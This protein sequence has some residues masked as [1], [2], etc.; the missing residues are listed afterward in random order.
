MNT[1]L[2]PGVYSRIVEIGQLPNQLG[3]IR[4]GFI[5]TAQKGPVN[6]PVLITNAQQFIDVFG[7]PFPDSYLG[8]SVL[9]YLEEGN[10]CYVMRIAVECNDGL[11]PELQEVCIDTSGSRVNGWGRLP[12][13]S[14]IDVGKIIL[15]GIGDGIGVNQSPVS[16][17]DS[18]IFNVQYTDATLSSTDG[19]TVATLSFLDDYSGDIDDSFSLVINSEPNLSE[20]SALGG[21]EFQIIRNSDGEILTTGVL[22]DTAGS[23][24]SAWVAVPDSGFSVRVEVTSGELD[25]GDTFTWNVEPDNRNFSVAVEGDL[26]PTVYQMP[27]A[28]Y[29]NIS[30]FV[31]AA[32]GLLTGEDYLFVETVDGNGNPVAAIQTV[33]EGDRIQIMSTSSWA[34]ELGSSLYAWDIPRAYLLG[35]NAGPYTFTSQNNRVILNVIGEASTQQISVSVPVGTN[36]TAASLVAA[37]DGAG[38]VNGETYYE[39]IELTVPGGTKHLAIIASEDHQYDALEIMANFSNIKVLRFADEVDILS[40]YVRGYRGFNDARVSLPE[41]GQNDPSVPRSCELDSL[42]QQCVLDSNYFQNIVGW[43]VAPSAGTWVDGLRFELSLFTEG[44]GEV[45]GRYKLIVYGSQGEILERVDDI[46]FDKNNPR[47]VANVLNP[48][49]AIGGL[50]GNLYAHWED[51]PGFLNNDENLVTYQV[52][53]PSQFGTKS[54]S[55]ASNGIPTDP[56]YSNY[57]DAAVIGNPALA[58]GLYA[59][60]NPEALEIDILATPGFSSGAV[61]GTAIQIVSSRG[62]AV[63]LVDPPFGLRPQ[64]TVDWHNGMLLSDLSQAINTSYAGLYSGWLLIFDQFSGQNIWVPPSGYVS[65][66]FSRSARDGEPWSSPAGIRR[67][68]LLSPINV[69][70]SPTKGEQNLMYGSGNSVNPILKFTREGLTIFGNRTLQRGE[71]PLSRMDVRL[72]VNNVRRGLTS[73][74]RNFVFEPNDRILWSQIKASIDPFL[75]DIQSRRGIVRYVTIVDENNNTPE[76]I[77]RGELWVSVIIVPNRSAEYIVLN[78]GV[79]RQN[80]SLSSEEV[81]SAVGV[82]NG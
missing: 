41:P 54:Y 48:G 3:P 58:T 70:Y 81:L 16:F 30:D 36:L 82:V 28:T 7:E 13:F 50:R 63:Y 42:S 39:A 4:P 18:D 15:R 67:A 46:S 20:D 68:R 17:H 12:V 49:S 47:Y 55:G 56:S 6:T 71:S 22:E 79:T 11:D 53:V 35:T 10:Q 62:D 37:I 29:T 32:N 38:V 31:A 34:L 8:Y 57:L 65:A 59:F 33:T 64:Q 43:F 5:G 61:I 74:L 51:R 77:D 1:Y 25:V 21:C 75:A 27:I 80:V 69:E 24:I 26:T 44:V 66:V 23:N 52:R 14:G 60:E 73:I 45:A 76:R 19:A 9:A 2:S 72:L 78:L 40:P